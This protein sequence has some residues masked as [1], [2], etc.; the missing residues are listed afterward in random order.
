MG[1]RAFHPLEARVGSFQLVPFGF[2][3]RCCMNVHHTLD[4]L[5]VCSSFLP[6]TWAVQ[7]PF[8]FHLSP[9]AFHLRFHLASAYGI[10]GASRLPFATGM[11]AAVAQGHVP[12][13]EGVAPHQQLQ[14]PVMGSQESLVSRLKY[15][16]EL[17]SERTD[18]ARIGR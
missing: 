15:V 3:P 9:P 16:L 5:S 7:C 17:P 10:S 2:Q 11:Q 18:C 14:A 4:K 8:A 1:C 12:Q 13:F 6:S